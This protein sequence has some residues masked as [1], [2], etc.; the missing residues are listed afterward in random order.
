MAQAEIAIVL[1]PEGEGQSAGQ[2]AGS[3]AL[4][5]ASPDFADSISPRFAATA[6]SNAAPKSASK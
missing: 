3:R 5:S 1:L 4:I 2:G 6:A